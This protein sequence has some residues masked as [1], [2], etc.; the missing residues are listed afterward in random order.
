MEELKVVILVA[1][2]IGLFYGSMQKNHRKTRN[3]K[4]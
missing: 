3:N 4:K 2:A 1:L